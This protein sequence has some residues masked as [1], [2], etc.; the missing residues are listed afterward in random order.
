VL[1]LVVANAV[2]VVLFGALYAAAGARMIP[3]VPFLGCLVVLFILMTALWVRTE[4]RHRRLGPVRRVGRIA[5]G[6]LVVVFA[7]PVAV[8]A[9]MFWLDEQLPPEA[10]LHE[11]R[12]GVMAL[13]LLA[14]VL[15]VFV[16]VA[17]IVVAVVRSVFDRR[18]AGGERT[19]P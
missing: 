1:P 14:L 3:Q 8:L 19:G 5:A 12:A 15:V 9:P 16:N 6:L 17:G 4:A 13:V 18:P 7:T 11:V 10:G 2:G